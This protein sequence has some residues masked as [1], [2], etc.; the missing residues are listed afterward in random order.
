MDAAI[1]LLLVLLLGLLAGT[2]G[3]IVG[4]G[5]SIMLMPALVLVFGPREA[6]PIMAIASIL[7]NAS[8]VAAW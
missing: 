5:T 4:F 3:G 6:V 2:V 8:R 1:Q 7:A